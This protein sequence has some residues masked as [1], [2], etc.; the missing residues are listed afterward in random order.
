LS[1]LQDLARYPIPTLALLFAA[2]LAFAWAGHRLEAV[3]TPAFI[4]LVAAM[5]RLLLLPLPPTLSD[6]MLRYI[7]DGRVLVH[8]AN[9]YLLAP[10]DPELA[11]LR[12]ELW[13]QMPHKEVPTV[14]PPLALGLF[15]ISSLL[16]GPLL[17][18]KILLSLA[19]L[20]TCWW[21]L[22]LATSLGLPAGRTLWYAWN[23]L[24]CLEIAGMGHVDSLM[25][26]A[27][28]MTVALLTLSPKR[29]WG[30]AAAAAAGVL[31][32]LVPLVAIPLWA[33]GHP[34]PL[35]FLFASAAILCIALL[36]V[37]IATDGAPPG[38][39]TYGISWEFN[40][41]LYEPLWRWSEHQEWA[42][43]IKRWLDQKKL[44]SGE[45]TYW[46][47]FY[48]FVYP[49]LIAKALL[50]ALFALLWMLAFRDRRP[51]L[52]SGRVFGA[53]LL[54]SA[55]LYPWYLLWVL[56]WAALCRHK[57][58]LLLS[59]TVLLSYLPQTM[60]LPLFPWIFALIWLPFALLLPTSRW[61][62]D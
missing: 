6:D 4:L 57:A 7:W 5:A 47:R 13:Q 2:F 32:K 12:D 45:H 24:V 26:S 50:A 22:K 42:G 27:M 21:L 20:L 56:P 39:V 44:T 19:D 60:G 59:A 28:V 33:R 46:N 35:L 16:P 53:V 1:I 8:G 31:A 36:P 49:R 54:C 3:A 18:L 9:P 48:P 41:P 10:E 17:S 52:A 15:S 40:G 25:V 37:V 58:W 38:L 34:R 51:V 23:P 11:P 61:S 30:S 43:S 55:T 14:Y 62:I 29:T